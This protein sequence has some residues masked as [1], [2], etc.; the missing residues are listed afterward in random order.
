MESRSVRDAVELMLDELP[1][2]VAASPT[3]AAALRLADSIDLGVDSYR[4]QAGL[5]AQLREC[6]AELR[7]MAPAKTEGDRVDDLNA[8]RAA[9]RRAA[10]AG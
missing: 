8:R 9:R 1:E 3:A 2:D 5:V 10:A 4:F 6:T 7:A